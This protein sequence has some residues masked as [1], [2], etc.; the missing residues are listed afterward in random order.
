MSRHSGLPDLARL[1]RYLLGQS[2]GRLLRWRTAC[3]LPWLSGE[4]G[5]AQGHIESL[6]YD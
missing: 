5:H 2:R 3:V 6:R 1:M 4:G